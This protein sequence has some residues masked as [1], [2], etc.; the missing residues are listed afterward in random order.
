MGTW[1]KFRRKRLRVITMDVTGTVISFRGTLEES[2]L[3]WIGTMLA[4]RLA[5]STSLF[6]SLSRN[7]SKLFVL[8][9]AD[10]HCE[11][12]MALVCD[13]RHDPLHLRAPT[14]RTT[15]RNESS[16]NIYSRFGSHSAY[17]MFDDALPFLQWSQRTL[18]RAELSL[19]YQAPDD[20]LLPAHVLHIG[21]DYNKTLKAH[22]V[23]ED[24][25]FVGS[26]QRSRK[27]GGVETARCTCI[28]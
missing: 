16:H 12:L 1:P 26:V 23:L 14:G 18:C 4:R 24:M 20:K 27:G 2:T 13:T 17:E 15:R 3:P 19:I 21:N 6:A 11:G 22:G 5:H 7:K 8:W 28:S 10:D 25:P 9:W